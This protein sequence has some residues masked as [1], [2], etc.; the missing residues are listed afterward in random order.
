MRRRV[1]I[2]VLAAATM[3]IAACDTDANAPA[4]SEKSTTSQSETSDD[5]ATDPLIGQW[6]G[7]WSAKGETRQAVL[8]IGNGNPLRATIDIPGRCGADWVESGRSG[9]TVNVDATV[10]YGACADN[11]WSVVL[12]ANEITASDPDNVASSLRFTRQ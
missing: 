4:D 1:L 6:I 8:N 10:T 7:T 9:K 3:M 12:S 5:V 11:R 2:A